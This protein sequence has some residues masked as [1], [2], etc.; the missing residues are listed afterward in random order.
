MEEEDYLRSG[1]LSMIVKMMIRYGEKVRRFYI[2]EEMEKVMDC[3]NEMV[4]NV[5]GVVWLKDGE[6]GK[7][8]KE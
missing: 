1:N 2:G 8:M 4:K 5:D 3:R 7:M 6:G